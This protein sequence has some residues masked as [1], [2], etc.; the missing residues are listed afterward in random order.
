MRAFEL[1]L[2]DPERRRAA[3]LAGRW[4]DFL[5]VPGPA[6]S[7]P[8]E[9]GLYRSSFVIVPAEG[10]AL[11]VSSFVVPAFGGD[12]CR[13]RLEPLVSW[14][15]EN[16]GSFF[17]PRRRGTIYAMSADRKS[18]AARPPNRQDWSY[19]GPSTRPRLET[20]TRV[21]LI[22]ERVTGGSGQGV[23]SWVA[24]RGLVL[25][26]ADGQ[27]SLLLAAPEGSEDALFLSTPGFY[28]ALF[29]RSAPER[30]GALIKDLL[31]YGDW[32]DELQTQLEIEAL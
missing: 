2:P 23:F 9:P 7:S 26:G 21:T 11:R 22:R 24:D 32:E 27:E 31:G 3:G 14:R 8:L 20:V 25:T 17:E 10:R 19:T 12:L 29:D 13:L 1:L 30:P 6:F 4:R 18:V 28:R 5:Y 16:L 15:P